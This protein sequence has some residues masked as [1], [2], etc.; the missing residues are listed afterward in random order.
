MS[1]AAWDSAQRKEAGM[2]PL[3]YILLAIAVLLLAAAPALG[4]T[5]FTWQP[6]PRV[7]SGPRCGP[8]GGVLVSTGMP[9]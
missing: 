5:A 8:P 2:K 3:K 6:V 1:T 9:R 4:Q 7:V